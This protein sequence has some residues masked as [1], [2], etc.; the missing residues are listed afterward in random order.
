MV[1]CPHAIDFIN[2]IVSE[3]ENQTGIL[4]KVQTGGT[5]ELLLM[6]EEK[7][8]PLCDVLWGGSLSTTF[9][10]K[11]LFA[12]YTS[13]NEDM[14]REEFK[15]EEGNMTRFTDIPSVLMVN[16]NLSGNLKIRGYRDLLNPNLK[17]RIA[18][19]DP[20]KSSSAYEHL[21]NMLY[22]CGDGDP[23]KGWDYVEE[24]CKNLDGELLKSS[25]QVYQGVAE[26]RYIVGLTFEEGGARYAAENRPVELVY[27][28]EG[29]ISTPDAVCIIKGCPHEEEARK[30]VDFVTGKDAQTI[31]CD[32]LDRRSVRTDVEKPESLPDKET[33]HM[34]YSDRELVNANKEQW[35]ARFEEIYRIVTPWAFPENGGAASK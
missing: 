2:P 25:S 3:F 17:G 10:K 32:R 28:E 26:G 15:N 9:P 34:I 13:V 1:Y 4:V 18:M 5:G 19:C 21:I 22:A 11:E 31:I 24:F 14:V 33:I 8:E 7:K 12:A 29:V 6:A 20:A 23:E 30:F 16:T 27:M 35:L